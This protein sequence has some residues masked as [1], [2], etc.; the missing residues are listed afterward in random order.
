MVDL[1]QTDRRRREHQ[2]RLLTVI[3]D[4]GCISS[5]GPGDICGFPADHECHQALWGHPF[6][7]GDVAIRAAF[8]KIQGMLLDAAEKHET[9][10]WLCFGGEAMWFEEGEAMWF[11]PE[12]DH[13]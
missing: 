8:V 10:G 12:E 6:S 1:T 3:T 4:H 7:G 13:G 5:D 9:H 2:R 11:E